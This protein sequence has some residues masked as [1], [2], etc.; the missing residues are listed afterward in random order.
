MSRAVLSIGGL[1]IGLGI[2]FSGCAMDFRPASLVPRAR[3]VGVHVEIASAP[4]RA[5]PLPGETF[6]AAPIVVAPDGAS[7]LTTAWLACPLLPSRTG[8]PACGG[9]PLGFGPPVLG[10]APAM[11]VTVPMDATVRGATSILFAVA[12]CDEGA[13]PR[14]PEDA[15]TSVIPTCEGGGPDARAELS[16]F[17]VP[18]AFDP[19]LANLHPTLD[20]EITTLISPDG[21]DGAMGTERAWIAATEALPLTA[22]AARPDDASMPHVR[23][24]TPPAMGEIDEDLLDWTFT[25]TSSQGDRER[26]VRVV[27]GGEPP[28]EARE[29]I[30][31]SHYLTAGTFARQFSAIEGLNDVTEP[32]T[33]DWTVPD[34]E[35]VPADGLSVRVWWVARDLRGGMA[36]TERALCVLP[37]L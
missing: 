37:P 27:P 9:E 15:S 25:I 35:D 28:M 36:I 10:A 23:L 17:S 34:A 30:Q 19:T 12:S 24:P 6:S 22:C 8:V 32:S 11:T 3:L 21:P 2:L 1:S 14:L 29:V 7:P 13:L 33:V 26:Y 16:V 5:S 4:E 31:I 18:I 20:D